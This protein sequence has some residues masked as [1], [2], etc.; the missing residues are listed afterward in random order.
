MSDPTPRPQT[1]AEFEALRTQLLGALLGMR[2]T[3]AETLAR[4]LSPVSV[5]AEVLDASADRIVVLEFP[6]SCQPTDVLELCTLIAE[7]TPA[8]VIAV[9]SG[10]A[11]KVVS[12]ARTNDPIAIDIL[13]TVITSLERSDDPELQGMAAAVRADAHSAGLPIAPPDLDEDEEEPV[14]AVLPFPRKAGHLTLVHDA[15]SAGTQELDLH[16]ATLARLP[17]VDSDLKPFRDAAKLPGRV[18]DLATIDD[19]TDVDDAPPAGLEG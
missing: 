16:L 14:Q 15:D 7:H 2:L 10:G 8:Q 12:I 5:V 13:E 19:S 11:A 9:S 1:V 6:E 3:E 18:P 17:F 4:Q